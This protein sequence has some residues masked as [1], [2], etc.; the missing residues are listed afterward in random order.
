MDYI[1]PRSGYQPCDTFFIEDDY[2][3]MQAE[4]QAKQEHHKAVS[5]ERQ[6]AMANQISRITCAEFRDDVL[7]QML[8]MDV[9]NTKLSFNR[10]FHV[11]RPCLLIWC[12]IHSGPNSP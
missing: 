4:R 8:H 10:R 5:R 3:R 6:Y 12:V 7:Q 11:I 2:H 1:R 9:S